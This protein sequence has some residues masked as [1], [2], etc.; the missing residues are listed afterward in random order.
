MAPTSFAC[1]PFAFLLG[2]P[3]SRLGK[4]EAV[5]LVV[6]R[7]GAGAGRSDLRDTLAQALGDP[8]LELAYWVSEI[9]SYVESNGRPVALPAIG[10]GKFATRISHGGDPVAAVIHDASLED[11]DDLIQ[12]VGAAVALTLRSERLDAELQVRVAELQASR[13]RI[14][15]AGDEQRR[16]IERDLHDGAQQRLMALGINLRLARDRIGHHSGEAIQLLDTSLHE[17][18]EATAELRE[19]ARGIHPAVLTNR[20]APRGPE[21]AR[22]PFADPS[23]NCRCSR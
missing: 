6:S 23:G 11:D 14:V 13:A 15:Q 19:L 10:S 7:D 1:V 8:H 2:L 20:G 18:N 21:R 12:A 4:A 9:S 5:S 16:R 3:R 22:E 17:L